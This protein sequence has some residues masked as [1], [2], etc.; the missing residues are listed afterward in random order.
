M[1]GVFKMMFKPTP[2]WIKKVRKEGE[3]ASAVVLAQAQAVTDLS[4]L[5]DYSGRDGW[6]DVPVRVE[7]YAGPPYEAQMQCKLSQAL[8]GML[9]SGMKVNIKYERDHPDRVLLV[10]DLTTILMSRVKEGGDAAV[11]TPEQLKSQL[12]QQTHDS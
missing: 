12:E 5:G 4:K 11:M 9:E 6:V 1:L 8:G 2:G 7:P 3:P 10:D